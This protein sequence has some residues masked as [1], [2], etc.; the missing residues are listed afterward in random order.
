MKQEEYSLLRVLSKDSNKRAL[1]VKFLESED[2]LS[3]LPDCLNNDAM[4]HFIHYI[5]YTDFKKN[6][7]IDILL[8]SFSAMKKEQKQIVILLLKSKG[9]YVEKATHEILHYLD[10]LK[11]V[12]N[13]QSN[14]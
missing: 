4:K 9:Q 7:D 5:K 10:S 13:K 1:F 12:D 2:F 3:K 8:D 11:S 14:N 6:D